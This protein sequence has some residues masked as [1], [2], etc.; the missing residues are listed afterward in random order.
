LRFEVYDCTSE[1]VNELW[2]S[3]DSIELM[4]TYLEKEH[5]FLERDMQNKKAPE[6]CTKEWAADGTL[7]TGV[8]MSNH[9]LRCV[10][11][12]EM[13]FQII[14]RCSHRVEVKYN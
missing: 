11:S 3:K 1:K 8:K 9:H 6:Y 7:K 10:M 14:T 12:V 13:S 5:I 4:P 2:A